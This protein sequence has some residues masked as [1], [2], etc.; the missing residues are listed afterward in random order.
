V[1]IVLDTDI[2]SVFAKVGKID[3]LSQ[4]FGKRELCITPRVYRELLVPFRYGYD[5][6]GVS[7]IVAKQIFESQNL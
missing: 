5:F 4:L 2:V 1:K 6:G 3:L 7:K